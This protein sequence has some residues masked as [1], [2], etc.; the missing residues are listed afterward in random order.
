MRPAF[1]GF[2]AEAMQFF[3]ALARHNNRDWFLPR[4]P[5]FERE[6]R[7]PMRVLVAAVNAALAR[8]APLYVTEPDRAIYRFY[9]DTR[10]SADKSPYKDHIAANFNRQ[11]LCRHEGAGYYFQVSD[12]GV[13]IGGGIYLSPPE[14]LRAM[15]AQFASKHEDFR[16]ITGGRTF[17]RLFGELQG[18][19]LARVPAGFACD[20]PAADLLRFKQCYVW[21]ELPPELVVTPALYGEIVKHFRAMAP[22]VEFLDRPFARVS[23]KPRVPELYF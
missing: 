22:F 5:L 15:R 13:G 21:A 11:G 20:H 23:K 8:F 16:K 10:F 7:E 3:R 1:P 19:R 2:S 9:R 18:D 6:V 12:K 4:K 17:R 14:T